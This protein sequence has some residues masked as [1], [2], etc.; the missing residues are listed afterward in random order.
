MPVS[1]FVLSSERREDNNKPQ[2]KVDALQ[3]T[4]VLREFIKRNNVL[5]KRK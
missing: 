1:A 2:L 5:G 3:D 4:T